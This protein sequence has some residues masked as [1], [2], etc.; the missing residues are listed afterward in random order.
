MASRNSVVLLGDFSRERLDFGA[1]G[2]A[3]GWSVQRAADL[4]EFAK[5]PGGQ[6]IL[7]VV[8]HLRQPALAS[9]RYIVQAVQNS[10]PRARVL[11]CHGVGDDASPSEGL[12]AGAY[13]TLL[14]PLQAN[15]VRQAFG[16]LWADAQTNYRKPARPRMQS[17]QRAAG[18]A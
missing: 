1:L 4:S 11:V 9:W 2:D 10:A 6:E 14:T 18:A 8:V 16:F 17:I 12:A 13:H 5:L 3:F 15:E 7:A